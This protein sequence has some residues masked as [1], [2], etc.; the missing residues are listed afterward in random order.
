MSQD[1]ALLEEA[2]T[3]LASIGASGLCHP[4]SNVFSPYFPLCDDNLILEENERYLYDEVSP[5]EDWFYIKNGLLALTC[6]VVAALAAGLTMALMSLD[7]LM[8]T[9]KMRAAAS[10]DERNQASAL[11]P[12][13]QQHHLLLVTLLLLNSM[14]N[15]ALP[16]F[17]DNLVPSYLAVIFSVTLVLMFGEILPS[18]VF[19]GPN[20]MRLASHLIPLVKLVMLLLLPISYPIAKLL[21]CLLHEEDNTGGF[22]NRG[23]LTALVRIQ[24]EERL[25]A[26]RRHRAERSQ[27]QEEHKV[28]KAIL[29]AS[30][31]SAKR[32]F[33]HAEQTS[34]SSAT[35]DYS[36][37][38]G[39]NNYQ[40]SPSI[41][42]DEVAMVEGALSMKTKMAIDVYTPLRKLYAVPYDTVLDE[43]TVVRIYSSGYSRIPVYDKNPK[44]EKDITAIRG[45][46]M[47]KQLI[48]IHAS[49]RRPLSTLP[50]YTPI[51]VSPKRNLVD[52]INMFQMGKGGHMALVCARPDVGNA[53]LAQGEALP[54]D[55]G[56]LGVVT[57]EDVL[58]ML[59]QEQILDETDKLERDEMRLA[60][61]VA[62]RWKLFVSQKK[63][64]REDALLHEDPQILNVVNQAIA[65]ASDETPLLRTSDAEKAEKRRISFLPFFN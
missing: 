1:S 27:F 4:S 65:A 42:F 6:V 33:E 44:K 39:R 22:Y 51:C 61:W 17:M 48:V 49:D 9:V 21:D 32:E 37:A 36:S 43:R 18:A 55:A 3:L 12:V 34:H 57:L 54:A 47:T 35:T 25:A 20:Q 7:P 14:A 28:T 8:L 63:A 64:D 59:I 41:H 5:Q 29:D 52:L 16:L 56:L 45:V 23:E 26:K 15:E 53:A 2:A 60:K 13:V 19:T 38:S 46:L 58:E 24:Y 62:A 50:L 40:R 11:L 31:R 10:E 30:V